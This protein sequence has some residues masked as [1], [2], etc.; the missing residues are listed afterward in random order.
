MKKVIGFIKSKNNNVEKLK[1]QEQKIREYCAKRNYEIEELYEDD[2][3][4]VFNDVIGKTI[5][6]CD[7]FVLSDNI[8]EIYSYVTWCEDY[9]HSCFETIKNGL[10]YDFDIKLLEGVNPNEC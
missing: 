8:E 7:L 1:L 4:M 2:I 3:E 10:N 9:C 6:I 5:V